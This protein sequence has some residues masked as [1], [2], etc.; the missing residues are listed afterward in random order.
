MQFQP[1]RVTTKKNRIVPSSSERR[2]FG[3]PASIDAISEF[4]IAARQ[5]KIKHA[6]DR[7][8]RI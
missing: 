6:T 2:T 1:V 4:L 8:Q 3:N 7:Y 5:F